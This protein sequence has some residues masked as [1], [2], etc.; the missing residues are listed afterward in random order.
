MPKLESD[1]SYT[2]IDEKTG[3]TVEVFFTNEDAQ[4]AERNENLPPSIGDITFN[5][6]EP[7]AGDKVTAKSSATD[8]ENLPVRWEW[9]WNGAG[10]SQKGGSEVNSYNS[11]IYS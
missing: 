7:K 2:R 3:K 8:P 9:T 5:P 1:L 10:V 11:I 6:K 4:K